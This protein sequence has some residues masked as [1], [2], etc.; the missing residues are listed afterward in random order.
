M[1][2]LLPEQVEALQQLNDICRELK[3]KAVLIGAIAY[4]TWLDDENRT[5]EDLDVAI[6]IDIDELPLLAEKLQTQGWRN[7]PGREHRWYSKKGVR[8]DLLLAGPKARAEGKITW[9]KSKM[10]MRLD[11]FELAFSDAVAT[12]LAPGCVFDVV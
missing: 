12:E 8:V 1:I 3:V 11:G 7:D 10:V 2:K 9:P 6:A 5:T 4:R